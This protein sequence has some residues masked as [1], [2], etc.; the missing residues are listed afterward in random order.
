MKIL[1][2]FD[3]TMQKHPLEH[4]SSVSRNNWSLQVFLNFKTIEPSVIGTSVTVE[5][6]ILTLAGRRELHNYLKARAPYGDRDLLRKSSLSLLGCAV[7]S[8]LDEFAPPLPLRV[9][10]LEYRLGSLAGSAV[11][12][13][14]I[15]TAD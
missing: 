2:S 4:A 12:M 1:D 8:W 13:D 11:D 7:Q 5:H 6:S 10:T 14:V 3:K 15:P 9:D